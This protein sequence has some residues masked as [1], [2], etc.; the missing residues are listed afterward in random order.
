MLTYHEIL[1]RNQLTADGYQPPLNVLQ[2]DNTYLLRL[3]DRYVRFVQ[4]AHRQTL[5]GGYPSTPGSAA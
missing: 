2:R 5:T 4:A 3:I 1:R